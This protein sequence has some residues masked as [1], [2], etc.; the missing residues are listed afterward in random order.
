VV[1]RRASPA[2]TSAPSGSEPRLT[3]TVAGSGV[4]VVSVV[5]GGVVVGGVVAGGLVAGGAVVGG[6]ISVVVVGGGAVVPDA[7]VEPLAITA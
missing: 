1:Q 2:K 3:V 5:V 7:P 4:A 6:A